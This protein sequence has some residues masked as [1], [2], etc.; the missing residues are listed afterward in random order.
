MRNAGIIRK[1]ICDR[2]GG[3]IK[4]HGDIISALPYED[5]NEFKNTFNRS[6]GLFPDELQLG[7]LK[8]LKGTEISVQPE[9]G[10]VAVSYTHLDVYKRQRLS[11]QAPA[12]SP[13]NTAV[14]LSVQFANFD[15]SSDDTTSIYS[16]F[17]AIK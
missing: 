4:I 11:T 7:F 13:N 16:A 17:P 2:K 1:N 5:I 3:L 6:F 8:I 14:L 9:H 10:Y 12:P 15:I